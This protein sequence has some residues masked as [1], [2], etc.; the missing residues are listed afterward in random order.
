MFLFDKGN[1]GDGMAYEEHPK[2]VSVEWVNR[3]G[4]QVVTALIGSEGDTE[5]NQGYMVNSTL[6][7]LIK[8]GSNEGWT[9]IDRA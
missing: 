5:K 3:Q 6:H 7:P 1:D 9:M 2:I 4:H 8:A